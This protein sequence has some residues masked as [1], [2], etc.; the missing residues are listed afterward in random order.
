MCERLIKINSNDIQ[1]V[2]IGQQIKYCKNLLFYKLLYV[3]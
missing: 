1:V 2:E 3:K